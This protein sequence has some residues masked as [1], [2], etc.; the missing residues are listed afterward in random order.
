[1]SGGGGG[2]SLSSMGFEQKRSVTLNAVLRS[3]GAGKVSSLTALPEDS[4][5]GV[6]NCNGSYK[7]SDP[8]HRHLHSHT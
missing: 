7:V 1:M 6:H 4:Q 2:E 5:L 8:L 3:E